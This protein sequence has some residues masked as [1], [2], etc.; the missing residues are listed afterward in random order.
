MGFE[1]SI[2]EPEEFREKLSRVP[3]LM[4]RAIFCTQYA[5]G[6]RQ[7]EVITIQFKDIERDKN[8]TKRIWIWLHT[9]KNKKHPKRQVPIAIDKDWLLS[10]IMEWLSKNSDK[11]D[12]EL[13]FPI[14]KSYI[15]AKTRK[16]FGMN[17]HKFR[18]ARITLMY[19]KKIPE[20]TISLLAGWSDTRPLS[21]YAHSRKEDFE[22]TE[23]F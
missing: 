4:D 11:Y 17:N 2:L 13:V 16:Y 3:L 19:R 8:D 7:G 12:D 6:C 15:R 1:G 14:S 5:T 22:G 21:V 10:H 20:H 23:D 18:H 9:L